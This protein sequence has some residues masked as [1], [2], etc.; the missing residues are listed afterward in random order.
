MFSGLI[1]IIVK[2]SL[3]VG[4]FTQV[5]QIANDSGR[6]EFFEYFINA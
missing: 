2:G 3:K 6:I 1:G 4:G 5:W